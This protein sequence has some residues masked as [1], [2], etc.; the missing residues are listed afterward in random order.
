[1][2]QGPDEEAAAVLSGG[3]EGN[4]D[5]GAGGEGGGSEQVLDPFLK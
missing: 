2:G 5:Q 4:V 3:G 1:M